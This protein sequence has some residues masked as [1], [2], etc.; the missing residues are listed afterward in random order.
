M[1]LMYL[2]SKFVCQLV[3][4]LLPGYMSY[5][6]V[7]SRQAAEMAPWLVYWVVLGLAS[8]V[9]MVADLFLVHFVPFYYELKI[10]FVLWLVLPQFRG[11]LFVYRYLVKPTL[12]KHEREIDR[13][14]VEWRSRAAQK[15]TELTVNGMRML[16]KYTNE[17]LMM[18]RVH[19]VPAKSQ[20]PQDER[21]PSQP[22]FS[23]AP[24][25]PSAKQ[26]PQRRSISKIVA[27]F[28][29]RSSKSFSSQET[30]IDELDVKD[31]MG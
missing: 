25:P 16:R 14:L 27:T 5:K 3:A 15:S 9:E 31:Y 12:D 19:S 20:Q 2:T 4:Y 30:L 29:R 24:A 8:T 7:K 26:Q 1:P 23:A 6:A 21:E 18:N 22:S 13:T 28:R 11:H 10:L 17:L